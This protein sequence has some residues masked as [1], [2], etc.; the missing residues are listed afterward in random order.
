MFRERGNPRPAID[1]YEAAL[2]QDESLARAWR[3][4]A[5]AHLESGQN[6]EAT[7]PYEQ[8]LQLRPSDPVALETPIPII[9]RQGLW[10]LPDTVAEQLETG[11]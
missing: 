7:S 11:Q 6:A 2:E 4:L 3:G 10:N 8:Y 5:E 9:G 1:A